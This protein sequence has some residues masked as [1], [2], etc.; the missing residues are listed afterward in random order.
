M[1]Y[2]LPNLNYEYNALEPYID[3]QTMMIHHTKHH[4]AYIDK[5]NSVLQNHP[6]IADEPVEE[7]LGNLEGLDIPDS[8]KTL[9][10]NHG[11]GYLNHNLFW[12]VMSPK[13]DVDEQLLADIENKFGS[14]SEFKQEF[15]NTA[16]SLFG[17]GWVYLVRDNHNNLQIISLP[18][19][20]SPYL[21]GL[22]PVFGI[23]VWEHAY[24]L[25]YQNRRAEYVSNWWNVLKLLP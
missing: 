6:E 19:Q 20:D 3:E 24:Y 8:D 25:K 4:Q 18:N 15:E 22:T 17:S 12:E 7:L 14:L 9:I 21:K 13:K 1:Q 10:R 2:T 5:L 11:G 23:D 16:V